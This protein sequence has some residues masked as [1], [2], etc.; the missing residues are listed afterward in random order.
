MASSNQRILIVE[1]NGSIAIVYESWLK[2][3]GF[4]VEIVET[5]GDALDKIRSGDFRVVL[6][7]LQLPD[8]DG[9]AVLDAIGSEGLGVTVVVVTASGSILTAGRCHAS[10]CL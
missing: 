9:L 6:L 8:M 1:D 10:R 4:D 3:A 2:K 7:D 5:G